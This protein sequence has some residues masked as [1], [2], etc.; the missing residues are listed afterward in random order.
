MGSD[1]KESC[2]PLDLKGFRLNL[3]SDVKILHNTYLCILEGLLWQ[4]H[5]GWIWRKVGAAPVRRHTIS[6]RE[7]GAWTIKLTLWKTLLWK[8]DPNELKEYFLLGDWGRSWKIFLE[9]VVIYLSH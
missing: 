5:G 8:C 9:E 2:L 6:R 1:H 4:Q 3:A 7:K